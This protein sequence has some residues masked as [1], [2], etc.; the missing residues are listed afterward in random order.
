MPSEIIANAVPERWVETQ[1]SRAANNSPV[2][3]P[4]SGT[5]GSGIGSLLRPMM[6]MA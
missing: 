5:T 4:I 6:L 1:P 3:P 2:K